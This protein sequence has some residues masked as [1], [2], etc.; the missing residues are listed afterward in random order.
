MHGISNFTEQQ[1]R[2]VCTELDRDG[3]QMHFHAIGDAAI[4]LALDCVEHAFKENK[5]KNLRHHIAH[6][7]V[8]NPQDIKRFSEL[9]VSANFQPFWCAPDDDMV[10]FTIPALG[11]ERYSSLKVFLIIVKK[12]MAVPSQIYDRLW[13]SGW[14]WL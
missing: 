12:Q 4:T 11:D 6:L 5:Q 2:E 1:L 3:F 7:Q 10:E 13:C 9:N 14:I 8:P